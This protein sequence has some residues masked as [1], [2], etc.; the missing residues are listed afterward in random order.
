MQ[1][2]AEIVCL[3]D[4]NRAVWGK[5]LNNVLII[6]PE[7][8]IEKINEGEID[9]ILI[10][11]GKTARIQI[12]CQLQNMKVSIPVYY[13]NCPIK[14]DKE[15]FSRI[16]IGSKPYLEYIETDLVAHCN[17][18][19]ASCGH[20]SNLAE[21]SY[22]DVEE[23]QKDY[24][25]LSELYAGIGKIRLLGG[26]PLL[27]PRLK[28]FVLIVRKYFPDSDIRVVTNGLL[29]PRLREELFIV[30]RDSGAIFDISLYSSTLKMWFEIK[31]ILHKYNVNY[32]LGEPIS[33]FYRGIDPNG[34]EN[35]EQVFKKC[36]YHC[37]NVNHG[38]ITRCGIDAQLKALDKCFQTHYWDSLEVESLINIHD[39]SLDGWKLMEFMRR[40]LKACTYC[41]WGNWQQNRMYDD[42]AIVK[43]ECGR[44]STI[45]DYCYG[46]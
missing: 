17:L 7:M 27:H 26:E 40:P 46:M 10:A 32:S 39:S 44:K 41:L 5:H 25:R 21:E 9:G 20:L 8:L 35:Y 13:M 34:N 4:N 22:V 29:I 30:M 14:N 28:E 12:I 19:C 1:D 42:K 45:A 33:V 11:A 36:V 6:S 37:A 2:N 38:Y 15:L 24:C 16:D 43:W 3:V 23:F 18:K 31:K